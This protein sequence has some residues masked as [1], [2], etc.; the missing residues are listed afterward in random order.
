MQGKKQQIGVDYWFNNGKKTGEL[1]MR[2]VYAHLSMNN[3][4]IKCLV[5]L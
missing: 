3:I 2:I 4:I 5:K 1:S